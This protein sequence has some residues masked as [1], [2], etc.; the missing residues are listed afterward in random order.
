MKTLIFGIALSTIFF[1]ACNNDGAKQEKSSETSNTTEMKTNEAM[2][3]T[4]S[5]TKGILTGYL[6]IKNALTKDD[7]KGAADAG[8][9]LA[10]TF[11]GFDKSSL[12]AEQAKLF[13][14]IKDDAREHAEHIGSNV[15]NIEHQHEHFETLS[16]GSV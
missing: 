12:T 9:E 14:D 13:D 8:N 3:E 10:K 4:N 15:G 7:D 6:E 1:V 2:G 11:D 5:L 16:Q